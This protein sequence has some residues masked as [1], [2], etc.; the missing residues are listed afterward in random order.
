VERVWLEQDNGKQRP[1]GQP[2][3]EDTLVQRAV[4]LLLEALCEPELHGCS[5]GFRKGPSQHPARHELREQC[6]TWP[7]AWRG[8]AEVSGL[9]DNLAWG[10]RRAVLQ[11]RGRDGGLGS[12]LGTWLHAG[13]LESGALSDP[14]KG[15]PPG[16]V[17]APMVSNIVL[18]R[19]LEEGCV[20]DVQPRLQGQCVRTRCADDVLIGCA[21]EAAAR[22]VMDVLPQRLARFRLSMHPAKT[23][24]RACKRPPSRAPS[25]RGTGSCDLLGLTHSWAKTR[26]GDWVSKRKTVGK[27]LR[28]LRRAIWPWC[29]DNRHT[30][31]HEQ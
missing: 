1:R 6:R 8:E 17:L 16:G 30:P 19:V 22:R 2:C 23:A 15:T 9:F 18:H 11:Q 12:R 7:M 27:R 28:R 5:H 13:V 25:A 21:R 14:A 4:V 31:W 3:C 26:R 10:H 29:R 20:Q 24:F